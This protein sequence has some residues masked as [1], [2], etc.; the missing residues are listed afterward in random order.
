MVHDSLDHSWD[1]F[2][3]ELERH[4]G[5]ITE[6][7]NNKFLSILLRINYQ[8]RAV[9][10]M[11]LHSEILKAWVCFLINVNLNRKRWNPAKIKQ[12]NFYKSIAI[13]MGHLAMFPI[14]HIFFLSFGLESF[15]LPTLSVPVMFCALSFGF[16]LGQIQGQYQHN[17]DF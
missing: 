9:T 5:S 3:R 13:K 14:I 16:S 1:S 12:I 15:C 10:L 4:F 2:I 8:N 6:N 11:L 17:S 7:P